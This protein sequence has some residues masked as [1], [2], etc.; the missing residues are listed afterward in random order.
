MLEQLSQDCDFELVVDVTVPWPL[1]EFVSK[2]G[3][4]ATRDTDRRW[5]ARLYY[6]MPIELHISQSLPAFDR[7]KKTVNTYSCDISRTGIGF[8]V[9]RELFPGETLHVKLPKVGKR[10]VRVMRCRRV[11]ESCYEIGARFVEE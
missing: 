10:K 8:L 6:R 7:R 2:T 4:V 11:C 5:F 9:D 1:D 3:L